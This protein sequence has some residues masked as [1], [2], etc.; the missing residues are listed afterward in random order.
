MLNKLLVLTCLFLFTASAQAKT[1][2]AAMPKGK[3]VD[4]AVAVQNLK[5]YASKPAKFKG[6]ITQV[7]QMQG[8]WLMIESKG[9]AARIK[10]NDL[11]F[12]PKDSKG[13]VIV[14]GEIKQV[15]MKPEMAKHLAEDAGKPVVVANN[16]IQIN[17]ASVTI[18]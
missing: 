16:E 6:R 5:A 1:Y 18:K 12:V 11:F 3:A 7:C 15:E 9:T 13:E 2:G 8:C 10:T 17:A 4:I 14:F